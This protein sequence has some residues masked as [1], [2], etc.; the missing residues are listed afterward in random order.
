EQVDEYLDL[1]MGA[2]TQEEA[3]VFWQAAQWD[4][5]TGFTTPGDAA[6]AWLVNLD[7]TYFVSDCLNIG[8]PQIEPHG[9]GWPITA[10]IASWTSTC[11]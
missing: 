11:S 5:S 2:P 1:A 10:N 9:H 7:H 4:D 8:N 6:W 3:N